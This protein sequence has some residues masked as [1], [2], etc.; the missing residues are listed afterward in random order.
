MKKIGL[1]INPVAGLG[2]KVGLKGSD[3]P[4]ILQKARQLGAVPEAPRRAE[5]ALKRLFSALGDSVQIVAARNDM[6]FDAA[7]L[8]GFEPAAIGSNRNGASSAQDTEEAAAGLEKLGVDLILFTGGDGTARN[9]YN[10]VGNRIAAIGIPAG[11]KMHSAV[12]A[13][14]PRAAADLVIRFFQSRLPLF[15]AE[16]MDIDEEAFRQGAVSAKLYGYLLVPG[17]RRLVQ[18]V[19]TSQPSSA[20]A[21]LQAIAA[22]VIGRMEPDCLYI[23]GPGTTTR[24][25]TQQLGLDK[26]LLGTDLIKDFKQLAADV[27]EKQLLEHSQTG[28]KQIIVTPIG[29]QG[30]IFGRGNQP[31]SAN[32]IRQVGRENIMIIASSEKLASLH[33]A[34]LRVDTGDANIDKMLSGYHRVITGRGTEAVCRIA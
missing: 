5:V 20:A 24:A 28:K 26:T 4:E 8:A 22:E 19:K 15:E 30:H 7:L 34:T 9:I 18:G 33:A 27:T 1:I 17:D 16:V 12:Y 3:T 21:V 11:V 32:V 13:V 25:I 2:G 29:G 23:L 10:A 6:G 31:I 14:N